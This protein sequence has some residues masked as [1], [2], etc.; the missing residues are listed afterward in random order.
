MQRASVAI[1]AAQSLLVTAGF[2]LASGVAA[3][4]E[5]AQVTV[6]AARSVQVGRTS[7]GV[8]IEQITLT[9]K[10]GYQD[11]DLTTQAG[12]TALEKRVKDT[13]GE[14]CKEIDR[15]YPLSTPGGASCVKTAVDDAMKQ[16]HAAIAAAEQGK[17]K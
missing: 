3:A 16:V 11:L 6:E 1:R 7:S 14:A 2:V 15:L 4:E 8:P 13:A 5:M 17:K 10:V 9:R 12:A